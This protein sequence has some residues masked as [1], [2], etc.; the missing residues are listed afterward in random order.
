VDLESVKVFRLRQQRTGIDPTAENALWEIDVEDDRSKEKDPLFT[1]LYSK[2]VS[3]LGLAIVLA[4]YRFKIVLITFCTGV[5]ALLLALILPNHY[6][7]VTSIL[8][9]QQ[10]SAS[11]GSAIMAQLS[12]LSSLSGAGIGS[13][14]KN[15]NDMQVALMRSRTVEDAVIDRFKLGQLYKTKRPSE[16]HKRLEKL[17]EIDTGTKDGIIRISVTDHDPTRAA[18]IANGYVEEFKKFSARLAFTEASQRRL[19]FE[20]QLGEAKET[21]ADAE[22]D[23]KKTEQ[24]TGVIQADTQTRS[25]IESVAQLRAE[26][27]AKEVELRGMRSFGTE[28]NP[29]VEQAVEQLSQLQAEQ[30]KLGASSGGSSNGLL[31][32]NRTMQ[33]ASLK[34]VRKL[35]EVRYRQTI[36]DLL[37]RQY[38]AAK[39]DEARQGAMVQVVDKAVPPDRKSFPEVWLMTAGASFLGLLLG[40]GFAFSVEGYRKLTQNPYEQWR[41]ERLRSLFI[42]KRFL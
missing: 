9:P 26:I 42:N 23:L 30:K 5:A 6:V 27:T 7:A 39:V 33:E 32:Q 17:V 15:P 40:V 29:A 14:L 20:N 3:L 21:L 28:Q 18:D 2:E 1:Q 41:L 37:A 35:R 8:P 16:T 10:S 4:Q 11:S 19:F 24:E 36:F 25:A 34:Y 13:P 31:I 38:E 22:E 12:S